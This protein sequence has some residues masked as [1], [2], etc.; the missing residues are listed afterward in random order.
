MPEKHVDPTVWYRWW[1]VSIK[2]VSDGRAV[3]KYLAPYVFGVAIIATSP[4]RST[5]ILTPRSHSA[6]R[7]VKALVVIGVHLILR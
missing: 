5:T 4:L 2:P 7:E 6:R 1:E 3:L